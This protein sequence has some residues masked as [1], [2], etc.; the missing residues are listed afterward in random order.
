MNKKE[1]W[2]RIILFF[3]GTIALVIFLLP[4][5]ENFKVKN[6]YE[7]NKNKQNEIV[8]QKYLGGNKNDK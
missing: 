2:K 8:Y 1:L 6:E 4:A 7:K 3:I 5:I